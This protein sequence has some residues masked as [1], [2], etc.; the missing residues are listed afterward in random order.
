MNAV[1]ASVTKSRYDWPSSREDSF[2]VT[3]ISAT[4][5]MVKL[6]IATISPMFDF[7][8]IMHQSNVKVVQ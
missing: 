2:I 6:T 8:F 1:A 3:G 4:N 7:G 5:S